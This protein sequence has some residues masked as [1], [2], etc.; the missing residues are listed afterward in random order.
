MSAP[1]SDIQ[2]AKNDKSSLKSSCL[3]GFYHKNNLGKKQ[4]KF[5]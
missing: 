3:R 5:T 1:L 4:L 2:L